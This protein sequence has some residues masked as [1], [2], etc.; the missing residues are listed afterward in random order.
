MHFRGKLVSLTAALA[1]AMLLGGCGGSSG[2]TQTS[3]D[4]KTTTITGSAVAGAVDGKLT[5]TDAKGKTLGTAN[6]SGGDFSVTLPR[7]AVA[8]QLDF[9][10]IG[11][12]TDEV[13]GKKVNLTATNCL[14]LRLGANALSGA[15]GT[16]GITPD[17]TVI[18]ELVRTQN[19]SLSKA[20]NTYQAVMGYT[21]DGTARP[22]DPTGSA[23]S[24]AATAEGASDAAFRV[25]AFSQWGQLLGLTGDQLAALPGALAAD[26]ADGDLDGHDGANPVAI[27]AIDF[28]AMHRASPLAARYLAAMATFAG[29]TVHNVAGLSYPAGLPPLADTVDEISKMDSAERIVTLGDGTEY[30]VQLKV[31]SPE[32]FSGMPA[33]ARTVHRV[34]VTNKATGAAVNLA[35]DE[36]EALVQMHMLQGHTHRTPYVADYAVTSDPVNGVYDFVVYYV[37]ASG[38]G[39]VPMGLWDFKLTFADGSTTLFHPKVVM[40]MDGSV[41]SAKGVDTAQTEVMYWAWLDAVSANAGGGH[42]VTLFVSTKQSMMSFPPITDATVKVALDPAGPW[43]TLANDGNGLYSTTGLTGFASDGSS[44]LYVDVTLADGHIVRAAGEYL[45]LIFTAPQ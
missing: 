8:G 37:M 39:D 20:R 11:S 41:F 4:T 27:D 19:M 17:T 29:D 31:N 34:T 38:M 30:K 24:W 9:E 22:F 5:V 2:G 33:T 28:N 40:P 10:V 42:D 16:V 43:T 21:P 25:G 45:Q 44:T 15:N 12:Y 36:I 18:R 32:P 26:L 23:P 7:S 14:A 1:T 35:A 13:S 6:V 3:S